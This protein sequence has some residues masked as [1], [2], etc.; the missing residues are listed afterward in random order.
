MFCIA[1]V[2]DAPRRYFRNLR[3]CIVTKPPCVIFTLCLACLAVALF[4][5]GYYVNNHEV[6]DPEAEQVGNLY[7][8]IL[9]I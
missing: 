2:F 6:V 3:G 9:V 8:N 4:C 1:M 5:L 7:F